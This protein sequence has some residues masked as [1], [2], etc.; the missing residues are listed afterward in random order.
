MQ[1]TNGRETNLCQYYIS[2]VMFR[3]CNC[4]EKV[5]C[6]GVGFLFVSCG[7]V[8]SLTRNKNHYKIC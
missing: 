3:K 2:R 5:C 8:V 1:G 7:F 4:V 6:Y